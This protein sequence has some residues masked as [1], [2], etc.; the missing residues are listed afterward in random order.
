[1][2]SQA[3]NASIKKEEVN[4]VPFPPIPKTSSTME[5][6]G[7]E[8]QTG[9]IIEPPQIK[10]EQEDELPTTQALDLDIS[11]QLGSM[12]LNEGQILPDQPDI[13]IINRQIN[14]YVGFANL[15]K[16][17][18]RKSIK[19]GF[20][21]NL[22]CVGKGGLGKTTLINSL[23]NENLDIKDNNNIIPER[24][25][26]LANEDENGNEADEGL[27]SNVRIET[28]TRTI[29][30][31]G[32]RL[33]LTVVDAPGFG[34]AIDNTN[35]W[36]PIIKEI[37]SRYD[38]YLDSENKINRNLN[39]DNR[40]HACLYFIEP[41]AH[42]LKP[43]D[44]EFC[45]V[46]HEKCNLIPVIAKSDILTDDEIIT[47]KERIN[48]QFAEKNIQTFKPP[49]YK[50]DDKETI[51]VANKLYESLPYAVVGS[52]DFVTD[53]TNPEKTVRGR[54]YPWGII[55]VENE[56]QSDFMLLRDLLIKQYLEE[57]HERTN[58]VLY[59]NYRSEK[60]INLGIKQDNSVFKE[61][62]PNMRQEEEK[63]LHEAKLAK[64]EAEMKNVFQLKVSE[65]EKKLQKSETELFARHKEM[66]D[67]LTKQLKALEEKK[68]QLEMSIQSQAQSSPAQPKK[69]GFL[70]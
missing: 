23:F 24:P 66:K 63:K 38:Q 48:K 7:I 51:D 10:S 57:L 50:L 16:Q 3:S 55:E 46:I 34:D 47:F 37:N 20:T 62:D 41:T 40:I 17:W 5:S 61:F 18:H 21:L 27:H 32:V 59:E 39:D 9:D 2:T 70:R 69:K 26:D 60:L 14:G 53:P 56:S 54:E 65:K 6:D 49:I 33:K 4:G 15:P 22:L 58:N 35:A 68:H 28:I 64:L 36:E 29:E 44:L 43:I 31:N 45:S 67:K 42:W 11:N 30:E 8:N 13:K 12:K 19:N 25:L 52:N 1:M